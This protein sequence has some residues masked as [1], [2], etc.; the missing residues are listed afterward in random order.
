MKFLSAKPSLYLSDYVIQYWAIDNCLNTG[1]EYRHT[2]I[3]TGLSEI[4]FYFDSVPDS[5]DSRRIITDRY[6]VSGQQNSSY[7]LLIK[8]HLSMFSV[9]LKPYAIAVLF[10]IPAT[11]FVNSNVSLKD[12]FSDDFNMLEDMLM[13]SDSFDDKVKVV[14]RFLI[15]LL[16]GNCNSDIKRISKIIGTINSSVEDIR[17]ERLASEACLS[18]KQFE[19]IFASSV[20]ITPKRFMKIVRFQKAIFYRQLDSSLSLTNLAYK[21]C[22]YD[23]SHMINDFKALCGLTPSQ[24]FNVCNPYSDYFNV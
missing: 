5:D 18:K 10:G 24:F 7:D 19:R 17:M 22:Y 2:I 1:E 23:Q 4:T 20:G 6:I 15:Y 11:E 13:L 3:P 16:T 9:T 14:E 12:V 8:G 21:C